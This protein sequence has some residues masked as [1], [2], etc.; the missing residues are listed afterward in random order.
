MHFENK[1]HWIVLALFGLLILS[2]K[3]EP[4]VEL[5][6]QLYQEA[7]SSDLI[8]YR[9]GATLDPKGGSPHGSFKLKLNSLA[10]QVLDSNE[11]LDSNA[12]FPNG[13]LIVK[14]VIK[15]G[16]L[17]LIAIMKKDSSHGFSGENWLWAEYEPD[18]KLFYG[19][20]RQGAGCT[21][22]HSGAPSTDFTKVFD[23][24]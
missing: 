13:A 20:S 9:G 21:G 18:G 19:V 15:K 5:D 8:Q 4:S 14:E 2:C 11:K 22:C 3:H 24:Q 16:K 23:V 1:K 6:D 7:L 12:S 10:Y 17:D